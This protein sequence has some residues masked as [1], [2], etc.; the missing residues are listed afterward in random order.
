DNIHYSED[1]RIAWSVFTQDDLAKAD[2]TLDDIDGFSEFMRMIKGV[3]VSL[4]VTELEPNLTKVSFRSKGQV[5]IND[6]ARQFQGGGHAFA[7][8][9]VLEMSW[10]KTLETLLP[11]VQKK[12][13]STEFN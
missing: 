2:A 11:Q 5:T 3:E 6:V 7:A 12:I 9:A 13:D 8:G 4:L 10:Q 1:G